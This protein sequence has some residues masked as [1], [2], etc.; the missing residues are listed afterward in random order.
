MIIARCVESMLPTCG[1]K[2][3]TSLSGHSNTSTN[4]VISRGLKKLG[5]G[6]KLS[7]ARYRHRKG[8]PPSITAS[9]PLTDDPDWSYIDGRPGE[10]TKGQTQRYLRDQ[11]MGR[12]MVKFYKQFQAVAEM[13]KAKQ[14]QE[15]GDSSG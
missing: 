12:T 5:Y 1:R 7:V 2:V 11:E 6:Q 8:L 10:M 3:A 4:L 9:G 13:R 15:P 14:V